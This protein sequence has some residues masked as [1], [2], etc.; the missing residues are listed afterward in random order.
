MK[1]LLLISSL[2]L[3]ITAC[4]GEQPKGAGGIPVSVPSDSASY[5]IVVKDVGFGKEALM[6]ISQRVGKSGT[7]FAVREVNCYNSTF[8]YVGE[9]NI[10]A[11]DAMA[12]AATYNAGSM[13]PLTHGSISYYISNKACQVGA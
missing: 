11:S 2:S 12:S 9:S 1:K 8:R 6:V 13:S 10:S 4:G 7:S 5:G 3:L